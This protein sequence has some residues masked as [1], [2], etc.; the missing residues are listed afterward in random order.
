MNHPAV[1]AL[2]FALFGQ[3]AADVWRYNG[4]ADDP[5]P[6]PPPASAPAEPVPMPEPPAPEPAP[7]PMPRVTVPEPGDYAFRVRING[8][9]CVFFGGF[10]H[11][12]EYPVEIHVLKR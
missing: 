12:G 2:A 6:E 10:S 1:I 9:S 5:A 4:F 7:P 3:V 8:H 11:P